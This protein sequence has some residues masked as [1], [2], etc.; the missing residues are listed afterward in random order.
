MPRMKPTIQFPTIENKR[1]RRPLVIWKELDVLY[2]ITI[3]LSA[4]RLQG[5]LHLLRD[6]D[7]NDL[8]NFQVD[9]AKRLLDIGSFEILLIAID[10]Q[11]QHQTKQ[12]V[13]PIANKYDLAT[14]KEDSYEQTWLSSITKQ[15]TPNTARK[16]HDNENCSRYVLKWQC[17]KDF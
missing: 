15:A 14:V 6:E 10:E 16:M 5:V 13:F 3:N 1:E 4:L 7:I 8:G 11:V 9:H 12:I 17:W 2:L